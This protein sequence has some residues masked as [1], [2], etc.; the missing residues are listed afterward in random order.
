MTKADKSSWDSLSAGEMDSTL[1]RRQVNIRLAEKVREERLDFSEEK[2]LDSIRGYEGPSGM[3]VRG[4]AF[5][6]EGI[7]AAK[8]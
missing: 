7:A 6:L 2:A 8:S 1:G 5:Q 3:R 4:H